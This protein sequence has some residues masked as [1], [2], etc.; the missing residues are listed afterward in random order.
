ME[1]ILLIFIGLVIFLFFRTHFQ[2]RE[3]LSLQKQFHKLQ[4]QFIQLQK[5]TQRPEPLIKPETKST[6]EQGRGEAIE[7]SVND[8]NEYAVE[9]VMEEIASIDLWRPAPETMSSVQSTPQAKNNSTTPPSSVDQGLTYVIGLAKKYFSEGNQIVRIGLVVLFFGM[10]FLAKYSI[11]NS[12]VSIEVRMVGILIAAFIVLGIGWHLRIKNPTYGL[13]MQG[14]GIAISYIAI[15]ASFKLYQLI[16]A[17][18][19]F[20]LLIVFS[21][22]AMSL[23]VLQ[24]SRTLAITAIMGGF[25]API[26]ASTGQGSHVGLF[27]YYLTLNCAIFFVAWFK[28]WRLLNVIGFIFTFIIAS[29]WGVTQYRPLHFASTEPFLIAFFLIYVA[30][31]ILFSIKQKPELKGYVDG[32]LVFGVPMVG[33]GLQ[34]ALVHHMEYGLAYS[35]AALAGFYF[36]VSFLLKKF[37]RSEKQVGEN[38]ELMSQAMLALGV[39][40]ATLTIPFA[41]D[42]RWSAASWAIE[43]AGFVWIAIRQQREILKYI[44]L[45][46]QLLGGLLFLADYPYQ[47]GAIVFLNVEFMGIAIISLSALFTAHLIQ[48]EKYLLKNSDLVEGKELNNALR[49]ERD[50]PLSSLSQS[51]LPIKQA[52]D[53]VAAAGLMFWALIWWYAGGLL[54]IEDYVSRQFE[55]TSFVAFLTASAGLWLALSLKWRWQQFSFFPW[56]LLLPLCLYFWPTIFNGHFMADYGF[57]SWPLAI[58]LLYGVLYKCQQAEFELFKPIALHSISYLLVVSIIGYELTWFVNDFGFAATWSAL[59]IMLVLILALRLINH[60]QRWPLNYSHQAYQVI[61]AAVIIGLMLVWSLEFNFAAVLKPDPIPYLPVFN[62]IDLVQLLALWTLFK[63]Y[64]LYGH[65][66]ALKANV[67][68]RWA[69]GLFAGF[70]FTWFNVLL[71]KTIHLV[72]GV[73]YQ[74]EALFNSAVVQT[75]ISIAWTLIGLVVMMLAS[76]KSLRP[77]W[78]IGASLT[79]IVVAKLFLLDLAGQGTIERIISFIVVGALLLVVGYFSP[80]PPT[81]KANTSSVATDSE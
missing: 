62:P 45:A 20:P 15:F 52:I 54:Q 9:Y 77:L 63:W 2:K 26:L 80:V 31:S 34:A 81:E 70:G 19:T 41:L 39:I 13:I 22:F 38:L 35:A 69:L 76:N 66:L 44:G 16:P 4:Q 29:F 24:N 8:T 14:G 67:D 42:G 78:I 11:E 56:L 18:L 55:L 30:I 25:A 59:V 47:S 65:R 58:A 33:F 23:A 36:L 79:A 71:L 28:S 10:S 50:K 32:T 5:L 48:S 75:S 1:G 27:S 57:V 43:G 46:I 7:D 61:S 64:S 17:E 40:F 49:K 68:S 74:F 21:L 3:L 60:A 53:A 37:T 12:L 72:A 73:Q 51:L 6:V